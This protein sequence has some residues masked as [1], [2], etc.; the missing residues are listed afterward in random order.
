[1]DGTESIFK[2]SFTGVPRSAQRSA[3][4]W[5]DLVPALLRGEREVASGDLRYTALGKLVR[6]QVWPAPGQH[7]YPAGAHSAARPDAT[8]SLPHDCVA[9]RWSGPEIGRAQR[10]SRPKGAVRSIAVSI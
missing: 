4:G 9:T 1:M 6:H 7:R 10:E 5:A 2:S 8:R 3:G